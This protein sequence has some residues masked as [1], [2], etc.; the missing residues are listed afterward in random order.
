[1]SG[2]ASA[3]VLECEFSVQTGYRAAAAQPRS[4]SSF[5]ERKGR[6]SRARRLRAVLRAREMALESGTLNPWPRGR[7]LRG[8]VSVAARTWAE[9]HGF[10]RS[11]AHVSAQHRLKTRLMIPRPLLARSRFGLRRRPKWSPH[12]PLRLA[13]TACHGSSEAG[14]WR[15]C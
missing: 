12:G 5:V 10:A 13:I 7:R 8:S 1:G 2:A 4:R 3:G 9:V 11:A 15:S 6:H 14:R